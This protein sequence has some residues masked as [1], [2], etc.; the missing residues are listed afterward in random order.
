MAAVVGEDGAK[1]E[2]AIPVRGPSVAVFGAGEGKTELARRVER[3]GGEVIR[4]TV[5]A[6][7][8]REGGVRAPGAHNI[9]GDFGKG[10]EPVPKVV[11]KVRVGGG[12]DGD[13]VVFA[14]PYCP[15]CS[16]CKG[17]LHI[18][19]AINKKWCLMHINKPINR[20]H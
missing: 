19:K 11:G 9:E 6:K 8:S 5:K 14:R 13:K 17:F 3:V 7:P 15:L 18:N 10:E 16:I 1:D 4:E 20:G 2:S 12:E